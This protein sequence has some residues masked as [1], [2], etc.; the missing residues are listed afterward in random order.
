M[1]LTRQGSFSRQRNNKNG[2]QGLIGHRVDDGADNSL[3]LPLPGDPAVE[4]VSNSGI[5]EES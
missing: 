3:L 4:E 1:R 5:G 2:H